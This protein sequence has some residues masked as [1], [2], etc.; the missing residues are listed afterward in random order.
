M[1]S[2]KL[3]IGMLYHM[4]NTFRN[5]FLDISRCAYKWCNELVVINFFSMK[6]G[7]TFHSLLVTKIHSLLVAKFSRYS[8]QKITHHSLQNLLLLVAEVARCKNVFF[9]KNHSLLVAKFGRYLLYKVTKKSQL[10]IVMDD[11][12]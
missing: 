11:K 1:H 8:L 12:T 10:N 9:V 4:N 6:W 3:K 5:T 7:I 2:I